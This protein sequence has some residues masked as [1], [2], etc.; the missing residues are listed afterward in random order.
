[1][2]KFLWSFLIG[3]VF[4]GSTVYWNGQRQQSQIQ[5]EWLTKYFSH[6][7]SRNG[8]VLLTRE[9]LGVPL[10]TRGLPFDNPT[11]FSVGDTFH[12]GDEHFF[13]KYAVEKI[14]EDGV[15]ISYQGAGGQ[16]SPI[17]PSSGSI[18]LGWK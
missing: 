15:I 14:E 1:M 3:I 5:E 12:Q 11:L 17:D 13:I 18:K 4:V 6:V 9:R 7:Q 10:Q 16:P 2:K 8:Q